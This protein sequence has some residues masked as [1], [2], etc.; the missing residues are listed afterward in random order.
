M[1]REHDAPW[2]G[3]R[4]NIDA[5]TREIDGEG[6]DAIVINASGCGT[7][8]KDYG[9]MFR[10]R[11]GHARERAE[12]VAGAG[13]GHQRVPGAHRLRADARGARA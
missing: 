5:W 1:G 10:A 7:T 12:R 11:P 6:L 3:A 8:V 4:A 13:A 2:R 9:F